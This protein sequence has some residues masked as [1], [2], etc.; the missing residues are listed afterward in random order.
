[1]E[2]NRRHYFRSGLRNTPSGIEFNIFWWSK[3]TKHCTCPTLPLLYSVT[4]HFLCR[5]SSRDPQSS[6][7]LQFHQTL[8]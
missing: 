3:C 8:S 2:I 6:L 1:M 5:P 7:N 4:S